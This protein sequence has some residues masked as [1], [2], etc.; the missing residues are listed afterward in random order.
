[1]KALLLVALAFIGAGLLAALLPSTWPLFLMR[2]ALIC[3][4]T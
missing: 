3:L 4:D 1:M 2:I